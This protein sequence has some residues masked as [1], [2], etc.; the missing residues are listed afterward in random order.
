MTAEAQQ[1]QR[2]IPLDSVV[3]RW[4]SVSAACIAYVQRLLRQCIL[5]SA[6]LLISSGAWSFTEAVHTY[7][8]HV[9]HAYHA[10]M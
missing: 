9:V 4:W 10:G 7:Y 1:G 2:Q 8:V 3:T 5:K 6:S